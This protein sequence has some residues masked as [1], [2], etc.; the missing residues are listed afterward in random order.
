[1]ARR[2]G[3]GRAKVFRL[4][5]RRPEPEPTWSAEEM[6]EHVLALVREDRVKPSSMMIFWTEEL[7]DGRE[8]P[9]RLA[10]GL[11]Y[12]EALAYLEL[13]KQRILDEWTGRE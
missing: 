4:V 5:D 7:P 11:T 6:L 10:N 2:I 8:K 3:R 1:M 13:E 12:A 9:T